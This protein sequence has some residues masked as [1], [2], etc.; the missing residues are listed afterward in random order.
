MNCTFGKPGLLTTV[1][2]FA[3]PLTLRFRF[4][5]AVSRGFEV[6]ES[7]EK[8]SIDS[9]LPEKTKASSTSSE[10]S[11]TALRRRLLFFSLVFLVCLFLLK[12][13]S[14]SKLR[15][16]ARKMESAFGMYLFS[17][18]SF[19]EITESLSALERTI[20]GFVSYGVI[21]G[22]RY[23]SVLNCALS[24]LHFSSE[25]IRSVL[26]IEVYCYFLPISSS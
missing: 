12:S 1:A 24:S 10:S 18:G 15:I 22:S 17:S 21:V 20:L 11:I 23:R 14:S 13:S 7:C 3:L 26:N 6:N 2:F 19:S 5:F 25:P 4:D 8:A 16:D 9:S